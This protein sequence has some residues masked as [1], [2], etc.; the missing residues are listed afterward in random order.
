MG[1]RVRV[2]PKGR[3][4]CTERALSDKRTAKIQ[5]VAVVE[6]E[7]LHDSIHRRITGF[8]T[9]IELYTVARNGHY[10]PYCTLYVGYDTIISYHTLICCSELS[11]FY[12]C[13]TMPIYCIPHETHLYRVAA[14]YR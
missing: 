14:M 13:N 6:I 12:E 10:C 9:A 2:P 11:I 4:A 8:A 3:D 1:D 7:R 5:L